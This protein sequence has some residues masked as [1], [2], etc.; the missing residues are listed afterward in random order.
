MIPLFSLQTD[1]EEIDV[2]DQLRSNHVLLSQV[3]SDQY[4]FYFGQHR[5]HL[6]LLHLGHLL[7]GKWVITKKAL[8]KISLSFTIVSFIGVVLIMQP[9]FLFQE[10]IANQIPHYEF[11]SVMVLYAAFCFAMTM[12]YIHDIGKKVSTIVNL[13]YSY[14]G[15]MILTC[16]LAN[17]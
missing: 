5:T 16:F 8:N 2:F 13:H 7:Q 10:G 6:H 11:F 12:L 15:H 3:S 4:N 17:F 14:M 1:D 9:E